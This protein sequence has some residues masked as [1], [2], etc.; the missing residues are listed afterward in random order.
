MCLEFCEG[1]RITVD[2]IVISI[3]NKCMT[4]D[5]F[6]AR[7]ERCVTNVWYHLSMAPVQV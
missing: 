5:S 7:R 2:G 4:I 1:R 3:V 6:V